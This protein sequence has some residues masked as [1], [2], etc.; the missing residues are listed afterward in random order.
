MKLAPVLA[1]FLAQNKKL[2]LKGLGTFSA[3]TLYDPEDGHNK[4]GSQLLSIQFEQHKVSGFDDDLID[5]VAKETGKMR[6]LAESDLSSQLEGVTDFLN[7]GKPYFINGIGSLTRKSDGS[8]EFHQEKFQHTEKKK[9]EPLTEKNSIPSAYE[10]GNGKRNKTRSALVILALCALAVVAAIWFYVK[11]S[12]KEQQS[13]EDVTA[14]T[15]KDITA[16]TRKIDTPFDTSKSEPKAVA[17]VSSDYYKYILEIT[18]QPRASKR[19]G[20]LKKINWPVEM[21]TADSVNYTLF[22]KLPAANA[23]TTRIK[24]SLSALSG[25]KVW[26]GR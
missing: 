16:D 24:D 20:Q 18:Q 23:D 15:P 14:E 1:S 13:L 5:F 25:K 6:V 19:Y 4:K 17:S 11:N 21:E 9:P 22:L 3:D 12:E 2:N 26:I 8:I 7:T 10:S